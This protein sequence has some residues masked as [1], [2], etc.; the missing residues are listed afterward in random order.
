MRSNDDHNWQDNSQYAI[1]DDQEVEAVVDQEVGC[2]RNDLKICFKKNVHN[3][4]VFIVKRRK[5]K[6][7]SHKT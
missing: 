2:N 1:R 7:K 6:K 3:L 5:N 4:K